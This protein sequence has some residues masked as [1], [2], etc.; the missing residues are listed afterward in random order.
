MRDFSFNCKIVS[1]FVFSVLLASLGN[2][3]SP[4]ESQPQ[5]LCETGE[6]G[7]FTTL[8]LLGRKQGVNREDFYSYWRDI[9]G[10]LATR[11]LIPRPISFVAACRP[12]AA[13]RP[14]RSAR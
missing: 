14:N 5:R 1:A 4:G 12:S 10:M 9:H 7:A 6:A 11:I 3:G 2:A 13:L 8:A